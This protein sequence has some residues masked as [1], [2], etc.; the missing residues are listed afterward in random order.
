MSIA[1]LTLKDMLDDLQ[2]NWN[3]TEY[4]IAPDEIIAAP[5]FMMPFRPSFYA[6]LLC[7]QGWLEIKVNSETVRIPQYGFF[8][9][10]TNMIFQRV[11]QSEDCKM[12]AVFFTKEFLLN[13]YHP[14][15]SFHFF[16]THFKDCIQ[17]TQQETTPLVNLYDV[18]R[19]RRNSDNSVYHTEL[20]RNL[21]SAYVYETAIIYR[22]KGLEM[23]EHL[24]KDTNISVK[25]HNLVTQN[26]TKEH[27]LQFYADQLF[28]TPKYLI[29]LIKKVTGKTPGELI[30]EELVIIAKI[31]LKDPSL[32][33]RMIADNLGFADQP[34]FS[35]FFK[36]HTG[37]SPLLF[38][39]ELQT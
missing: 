13:N 23:T 25:F 33:I 7:V 6:V 15:E 9:G 18:L 26:C 37:A 1:S 4:Y 28:V 36:K 16:S 11:A 14:F 20:I 3:H 39:K 31:Q 10:G 24:T 34:S 27:R 38:R 29:Q 30:D 19:D 12:K 2:Y 35:K 5:R 8:A 21:I 32:S 22:Q 17:L